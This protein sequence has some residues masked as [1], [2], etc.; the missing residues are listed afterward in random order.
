LVIGKKGKNIPEATYQLDSPNGSFPN[1][2]F[3]MLSVYLYWGNL[4]SILY[5]CIPG[6]RHEQKTEIGE[7]IQNKQIKTDRSQQ[8]SVLNSG[9]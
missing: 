2:D 9:S 8:R 1:N 5:I 6:T 3:S 7:C 4:E